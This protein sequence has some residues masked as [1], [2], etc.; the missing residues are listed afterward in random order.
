MNGISVDYVDS[1]KCLGI[2]VDSD[3][4]FGLHID[5]LSNRICFTLRRLYALRAY[6]PKFVR[7]RLANALLMSQLNYCFEIISGTSLSNIDRLRRLLRKIIRYIFIIPLRD[8]DRV[9]ECTPLF[10]RCT[11]HDFVRLRLLLLFYRVMKFGHPDSIVNEFSFLRSTRNVQIEIPRIH[12]L[13]F[14]RSFK[15]RISRIWN[16]LPIYL[17]TFSFSVST[18]KKKVLEYFANEI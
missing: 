1:L 5:S 2:I 3:L 4:D 18:F 14:E 6:T 15:I 11:F 12:R 9:T 8:H 17:R 7:W 10:L 13:V 16:Q